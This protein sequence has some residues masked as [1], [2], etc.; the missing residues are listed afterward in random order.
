MKFN[1]K[2]NESISDFKLLPCYIKS[3]LFT[4]LCIATYGCQLWNFESREVHPFYVARRKVVRI[5]M[6]FTIYYSLQSAALNNS[7]L[8]QISLWKRG[9]KSIWS[10]LKSKNGVVKTISQ[11]ASQ[12]L[13]SVFLVRITGISSCHTSGTNPSTLSIIPEWIIFH[14]IVLITNRVLWSET[15]TITDIPVSHIH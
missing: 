5:L 8:I 6:T 13:R 7:T 14:W 9:V 4:T 3:K 10:C 15:C 2:S 12:L 11:F 1:M